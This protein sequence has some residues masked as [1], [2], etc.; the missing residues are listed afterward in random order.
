MPVTRNNLGTQPQQPGT[1]RNAAHDHAGGSASGGGGGSGNNYSGSDLIELTNTHG[2]YNSRYRLDSRIFSFRFKTYTG[3]MPFQ[4][5]LL[6]GFR[7]F[8]SK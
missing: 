5:F 7:A 4:D 3:N 2:S 6:N 1:S 8:F